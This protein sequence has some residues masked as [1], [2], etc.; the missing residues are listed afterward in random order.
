[1]FRRVRW[2]LMGAGVGLGSSWWAQRKARRTMARLSP[3]V[4]RQKAAQEMVGR[5]R[6][7]A[8]GAKSAMRDTEARWRDRSC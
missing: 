8:E 4:L 3:A 7:A 5:V 1:M 2:M 6:S